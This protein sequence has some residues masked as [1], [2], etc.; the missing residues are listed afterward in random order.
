M[1]NKQGEQSSRTQKVAKNV[2]VSLVCQVI[3]LILQFLCRV[4][5]VHALGKEYLGVS[6]L[7]TNILT[8][9]SFAELGIGSSIMFHLYRPLASGDHEK[10]KSLMALYKHAYQIIGTFIGV[11]GILLLPFLKLIVQTDIDIQESLYVIY[12]LYLFN[13]VSSYFLSYKKSII[14]ADQRVYIVNLY[15]Q[16]LNILQISLQVIVLLV[17]KNFILYLLIQICFTILVNIVISRRANKMYPELREK[18]VAPLPPEERREIF[19]NVRALAV[20]KI[21]STVLN[22]T[23][24]ILVSAMF[25]VGDVGIVS[26]YLMINNAFSTILGK[27]TESFT[28]SVG[29]LNTSGNIDQ[30]YRVF[31]DIFF[32]CAWLFG[33]VSIGMMLL[34]DQVVGYIFG[35]EYI[36][37][38]SVRCALVISFY[39][40]SMQYAA[41]SYRTTN[42]LFKQGK[43][44]PAC[45]A[46]L[47]IVLSVFLGSKIGLSGIFFAT[48][49]SRFF[50]I[51]ITD[52]YLVYRKVFKMNPIKYY[53]KYFGFVG[54]FVVIYY[55]IEQVLQYVPSNGL[56]WIIAEILIV[57]VLYHGIM[58]CLFHKTTEFQDIYQKACRLIFRPRN[59]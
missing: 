28:A 3:G 35:A 45:A 8:V 19:S 49:I 6:G 30:R 36:V 26:N 37:L 15:T 16:L 54:L 58:I 18:N 31:K 50:T 12:L 11:S 9:L 41:F 34:S 40:S 59:T 14:I 7:F 39:V 53:V 1:N 10:I 21:G 51:T 32:L 4:V 24:N 2:A 23:D 27:V 46:V 47:N 42:G 43:I 55:V 5:F 22:G 44:A 48:A 52:G 17:S 57:T 20:Y 33:Y 29:N 38:P 25:S 13:T 56:L